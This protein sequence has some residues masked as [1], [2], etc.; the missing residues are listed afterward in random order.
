MNKFERLIAEDMAKRLNDS[1]RVQYAAV[2]DD[3]L[4]IKPFAP[5]KEINL[6]LN[7]KKQEN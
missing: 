3:F 1:G 2:I 7:I 4:V 5:I 6:T